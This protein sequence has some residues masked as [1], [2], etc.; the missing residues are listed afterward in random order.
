[1][2][3]RLSWL[4]LSSIIYFACL[5]TKIGVLVFLPI[6][7]LTTFLHEFSHAIVCILT[8]GSVASLQINLDCS[9]VTATYGGNNALI[10]MG[11]YIGSCV[12]SNLL[13]RFSL[14]D[15]ST[16]V[17]SIFLSIS[18]ICVA[19]F[20]FSNDLTAFILVIIAISFIILAKLYKIQSFLLQFIAIACLI[21]IIQDFNVGPTSDLAEF[22]KSVGLFSD[23]I[24]MYI[25]LLIVLLITIWNM[26]RII[27]N[28]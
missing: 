27:K 6:Q 26:R 2:N 16:R 13:M 11:G 12:F 15:Y 22:S 14:N 4:I 25:W 3:K 19:Y 1:M 10:C 21:D 24:W 20:W 17:I 5:H 18:C 28:F 23:T 8:G 9:G 7:L